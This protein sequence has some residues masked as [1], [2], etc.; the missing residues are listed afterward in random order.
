MSWRGMEDGQDLRT[1]RGNN[2]MLKKI[3]QT[4][5]K[6]SL[7]VNIKLFSQQNQVY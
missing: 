2:R 5:S 1:F 7:V 4:E 3:M 6:I